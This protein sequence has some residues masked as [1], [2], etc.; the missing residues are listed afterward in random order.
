MGTDRTILTTIQYNKSM[1]TLGII[2]VVTGSFMVTWMLAA[3][4]QAW[5]GRE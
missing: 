2:A 1:T 5:K 4:W 3:A